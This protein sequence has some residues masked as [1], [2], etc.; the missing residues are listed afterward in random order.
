MHELGQVPEMTGITVVIP[1]LHRS[2]CLKVCVQELLAQRAGPFEIL[3]VDQS[4]QIDLDIINMAA[5]TPNAITYHHVSF[6]G[7]PKARNFGWHHAR[8][9]ALLFL[10]DDIHCHPN[11]VS[12]HLRRLQEP[13]VGVVAGA[14][15]ES[16]P[17]RGQKQPRRG[18][19]HFDRLTA[20]PARNWW[21]E[22]NFDVDH[23]PGGNFSTWRC[24]LQS[25]GGVDE[26]LSVGAALYEETDFC[27]RAKSAGYRVVFA[28]TARITHL[29][30]PGGGCRISISEEYV[31]GLAHNRAIL[32]GRHLRWFNR[33]IAIGRLFATG[34]S[35]AIR[36]KK[37]GMLRACLAGAR[38]GLIDARRSPASDIL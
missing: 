12:E 4:D 24:V 5:E 18:P 28:G 34:L 19:G 32:I 11:L 7:L 25:C 30:L 27:L 37:S 3:V 13:G 22:G 33:P 29:A 38:S 26:L 6:I 9:D 8:Y 16:S 36:N 31:W 14:V 20:V 1:T 23:A 2:A 10:D 17:V 15:E 21:V 35:Y